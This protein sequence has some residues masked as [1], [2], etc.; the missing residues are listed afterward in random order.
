MFGSLC[1]ERLTTEPAAFRS[2]LTG[3]MMCEHV[4]DGVVVGESKTLDRT[5]T[6]MSKHLLMK[7]SNPQ[8]GS[9]T[10]F[11]GSC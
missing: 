11:L 3:V 5:V 2:K 6:A 4:D 7:T 9:E 1:L 10:K 8:L